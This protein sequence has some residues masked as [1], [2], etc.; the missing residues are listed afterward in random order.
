MIIDFGLSN[1]S[2]M[3]L[4]GFEIN[5][6]FLCR[7]GSFVADGLSNHYVRIIGLESAPGMS[8]NHWSGDA[9]FLSVTLD[10]LRGD[11]TV[12]NLMFVGGK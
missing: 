6:W 10:K 7:Y 9:K 12:T 3:K 1:M 8:C 2:L 11:P 4:R 5:W